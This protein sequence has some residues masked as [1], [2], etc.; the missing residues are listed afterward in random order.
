MP[1]SE[2]CGRLVAAL[3]VEAS[4]EDDVAVLAVQFLPEA[5]PSFHRVFPGRAEELRGLRTAMRAWMDDHGV[6]ESVRHALLLAVGEAC[7]NAVE[8]A[9]RDGAAGDVHVDIA[10]DG[11]R[12]LAV[13]VR[14]FGRFRDGSSPS[15]DR[16]RGTDIMRRLTD[17]LRARLDAVRNDGTIP[18]SDGRPDIRM[19]DE[20]AFLRREER[21]GIIVVHLQRR[22]RPLE[23]R[24][25]ARADPP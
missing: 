20:L 25:A 7:A 8:H 24:G 3:G 10:E 6:A 1:S 11:D 14:D 18:P 16:G 5:A 19:T 9:Y 22:D 23:R 13:S 17:R 2:V 4:R 21:D 15:E 12:S